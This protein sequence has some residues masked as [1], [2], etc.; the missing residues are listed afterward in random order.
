MRRMPWT[1]CLWPGLP[2][3]WTYGSWG[4]MALAL[5]T[6]AVLDLLLLVSFGWSE[7]IGPGLRN[8]LWTLFGVAWILGAF[9][10][11][12]HCGRH[13]AALI[14]DP[15]RDVFTEALDHYLKGDYYQAEHMLDGLLRRNARDLDAR[16]MLATLL[17]R[18]GR[19]EEARQQLDT[20]ARFEGAGKW[21][22]EIERERTLLK[23]VKTREVAAA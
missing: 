16:L 15:L 14:P 20:L 5:G 9:W 17:R 3:L 7:L 18:A 11:A 19:P 8:T 21:Q 10:S 2:Q 1:T 22:W 12:R 6:A 4:G 13:V 23:K